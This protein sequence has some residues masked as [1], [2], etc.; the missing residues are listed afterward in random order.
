VNDTI[1]SA[2]VSAFTIPTATPES[3]GTAEWSATTLVLVKVEAQN[4]VGLGYSYANAGSILTHY[5]LSQTQCQDVA[6]RR[7][8]RPSHIFPFVKV[9]RCFLSLMGWSRFNYIAPVVKA[10]LMEQELIGLNI[11]QLCINRNDK[12]SEMG[13]ACEVVV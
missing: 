4:V 13:I 2:Q 3:D 6:Q 9:V 8:R 7:N 11:K 12:R 1:Q 10:H 5:I